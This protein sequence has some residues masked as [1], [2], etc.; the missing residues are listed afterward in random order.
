MFIVKYEKEEDLN[1]ADYKRASNLFS[2]L[3]DAPC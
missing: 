1:L 3:H 2:I